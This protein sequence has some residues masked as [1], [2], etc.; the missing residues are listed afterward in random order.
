MKPRSAF[1]VTTL[2]VSNCVDS[3]A[4]TSCTSD[5]SAIFAFRCSS[6]AE[7][8]PLPKLDPVKE[9]QAMPALLGTAQLFVASSVFNARR[10]GALA[11]LRQVRTCNIPRRRVRPENRD[12][13]RSIPSRRKWRN[14]GAVRR[15]LRVCVVEALS[16]AA[17]SRRCRASRI[18]PDRKRSGNSRTRRASAMRNAIEAKTN[19]TRA[20]SRRKSTRS[21]LLSAAK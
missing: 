11:A 20:K 9:M 8:L 18:S 5:E 2:S 10:L 3:S 12:S 13:D 16:P 21:I 7:Q 17:T 15:S 19:L 1:G 4:R 14:D 6:G